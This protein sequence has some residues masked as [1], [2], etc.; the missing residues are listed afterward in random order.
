MKAALDH[1]V[2][3]DDQLYRYVLVRD[4]EGGSGGVLVLIMLNPSTADAALN[5]PTITRA[6]GF[7]KRHGFSRLIVLNLFAYRATDPKL[8]PGLLDPIG[9]LNNTYLRAAFNFHSSATFL[10]AWGANFKDWDLKKEQVTNVCRLAQHYRVPL[11]CLEKNADGSPK[12]PLYIR[13]DADL[14]RWHCNYS[15]P[16]IL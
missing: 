6:M 12:H 5:D 11:Y 10:V 14:K 8:L 15:H 16:D 3:S 9:V 2:I 4:I 13:A 7:A 1:T